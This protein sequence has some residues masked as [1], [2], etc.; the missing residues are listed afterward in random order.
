MAEELT[1]THDAWDNGRGI[2]C[3][4]LS[5]TNIENEMSSQANKLELKGKLYYNVTNIALTGLQ[6]TWLKY[7]WEKKKG[8]FPTLQTVNNFESPT[9]Y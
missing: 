4:Q 9:N 1:W 5:L 2:K 6:E 7:C 3:R 8:F